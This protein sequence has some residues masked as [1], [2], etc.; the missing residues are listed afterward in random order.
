MKTTILISI[1]LLCGVVMNLKAQYFIKV[2]ASINSTVLQEVRMV[3]IYLPTDYYVDANVKYPT[4]YFLH[5][6]GEDNSD[7]VFPAKKYFQYRIDSL[8]CPAAI[9]VVPDGSCDQFLGSC[10]TNSSLYG[11]FED[12]LLQD[13]I[14]FVEN[15]FRVISNKYYRMITGESIGGWAA[16]Y[17]ASKHTDKFR[18]CF[19]Y[20]GFLSWDTAVMDE[21]KTLCYNENSSYNLDFNQGE[22]TQAF[23]TLCGA[24]SPNIN[25]TNQIEIP[26]DNNGNWIDSTLNKWQEYDI[27]R[28]VKDLPNEESLAWYLAYG[29]NDTYPTETSYLAFIDSL[30]AY[31]INC[32]SNHFT[33]GHSSST[34]VWVDG[35]RWMD[36]I[37]NYSY[38]NNLAV[39]QLPLTAGDFV[40]FPNPSSGLINI[41][42]NFSKPGPV[43]IELWNIVGQKEATLQ[44][45]K[46]LYGDNSLDISAFP[47]G[48]YFIRI[49]NGT[50]TFTQKIIKTADYN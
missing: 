35:I 50:E 34:S 5:Q 32:K 31:G 10:F 27:S 21:W 9:F 41:S 24:F 45:H 47:N 26:F 22:Y 1:S 18:G 11:N 12:Y 13:I 23:F 3:D 44:S 29:T 40:I 49:D 46:Q 17:I 14:P 16:A 48:I 42:Y 19:P 4:I 28:K 15:E 36:S 25:L 30:D 38:V 37:L 20:F 8:D 43:T 7:G 6:E 2:E 39:E 33:G